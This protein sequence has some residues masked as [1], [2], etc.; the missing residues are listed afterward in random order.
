M[1]RVEGGEVMRFLSLWQPWA[2]LVAIGAK[3]IETRS[4]ETRYRGLVGIHATAAFP[5]RARTLCWQPPFASALVAG[6]VEH[7]G[8]LPRGAVLAV[9]RLVECR[10]T[11]TVRISKDEDAFGDY[12]AG[13]FAWLLADIR[14]LPAPIPAKGMQGLWGNP[15]LEAQV[16]RALEVQGTRSTY[17]EA[18]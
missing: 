12:A 6:G 17:T 4:W 13:R 18:P 14:R 8:N 9:V 1:L 16:L 11:G 7:P 5:Q 3:R 10:P 15:A 2:S